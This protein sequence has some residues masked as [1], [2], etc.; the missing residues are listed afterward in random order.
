MDNVWLY[1]SGAIWDPVIADLQKQGYWGKVIKRIKKPSIDEWQQLKKS[2][3]FSL[4][5]MEKYNLFYDK[6]LEQ[7]YALMDRLYRKTDWGTDR[8]NS[9]SFHE[10]SGRIKMYY[11]FYTISLLKECIDLVVFFTAPH[12]GWD[13]ILYEVA[14]S[15]GITT[16]I[17]DQSKFPNKFFHYFDFY[18]YGIFKTSKILNNISEYKIVKKF[19]KDWF[20]MKKN[21]GRKS[22]FHIGKLFD[23]YRYKNRI[24]NFIEA[25]DYLRLIKEFCIK[26]QRPQ[27]FFR[28][29]TERN[30]K[31]Q[32]KKNTVKDYSLKRKY[33]YF[34]LHTQPE[35]ATSI[36]GGIYLDQALAIERLSQLIPN[37]WFIYVKESPKQKGAYRDK[38][39]FKR[40]ENIPN[41]L[42]LPKKANT[43]SLI[44]NSQFVATIVGT[45]GWEAITGG[46]NVLTFGWGRWYKTLPGV[47]EYE[48]GVSMDE[49]LNNRIDHDLLQKRT[50]ALYNTCGT[51][52]IYDAYLPSL[53]DFSIKKNTETV[54]DSLK[55]ILYDTSA[56]HF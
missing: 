33:V 1:A 3:S 12:M 6:L 44:K 54:V 13:N 21:Y 9:S 56:N 18:D 24:K 48:K 31:K 20:Y 55:A 41:L 45:A 39:F 26:D 37:D 4:Q 14:K 35:R 25:N 43:F 38:L 46:K 42:L 15:H 19:E 8:Y 10:L 30:Y 28:F 40:L 51:G 16:L 23:L 7:R 11:D 36:W 47:Y 22:R 27:S 2:F 50:A 49:L 29:Y 34:P 52:I 53:S 32:F 5:G 17:L